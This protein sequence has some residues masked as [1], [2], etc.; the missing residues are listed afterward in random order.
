VDGI[1]VSCVHDWVCTMFFSFTPLR[2]PSLFTVIAMGVLIPVGRC[3]ILYGRL[4]ASF[5]TKTISA[6]RAGW[7]EF[8]RLGTRG[9]RFFDGGIIG[10]FLFS[11]CY[12]NHIFERVLWLSLG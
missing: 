4:V 5:H 8:S 9:R 2:F 6:L 3:S 12:I 10:Y 11:P 7:V 1:E